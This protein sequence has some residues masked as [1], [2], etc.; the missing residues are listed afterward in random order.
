MSVEQSESQ[1]F[2][3]LSLLLSLVRLRLTVPQCIINQDAGAEH[4]DNVS[5]LY[6]WTEMAR[7]KC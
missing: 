6:L 4:D 2:F 1:L 5:F 7:R 3:S